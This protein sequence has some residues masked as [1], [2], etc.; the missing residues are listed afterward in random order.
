MVH[1]FLK[2][3][4]ENINLAKLVIFL[5]SLEII[6]YYQIFIIMMKFK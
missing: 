3:F 6:H 4:I 2:K 5:C 1:C